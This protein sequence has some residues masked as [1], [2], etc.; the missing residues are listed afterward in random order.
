M[1]PRF[2]EFY[3]Q[4]LQYI[5]E[6]GQEFAQRYPKIAGR[7]GLSTTEV[8]DPYVERLLEGFA[9]LTGRVQY[10]LDQEFPA[11][12]EQL[13][14]CLQ[15]NA[16]AP[17]PSM[18]IVQIIPNLKDPQLKS[19]PEISG[20]TRLTTTHRSQRGVC[21][22]FRTSQDIQVWPISIE[23]VD[24][25]SQPKVPVW[26]KDWQGSRL[27]ST[28]SVRLQVAEGITLNQLEGLDYLDFFINSGDEHAY[29]FLDHLIANQVLTWVEFDN[30]EFS[31][32]ALVFEHLGFDEHQ[33]LLPDGQ[34]NFSGFRLIQEMMVFP[35]K[36]LFFRIKGLK[37]I[38]QK[39]ESRNFTIQLG[40]KQKMPQLGQ[41]LNADSLA[42]FCSP[43]I[44]W[45]E[46]RCD[47]STPKGHSKT[48]LLADRVH[49]QDYEIHS[50]VRVKGY[51]T[52]HSKGVEIPPLFGPGNHNCPQG[53]GYVFERHVSVESEVRKTQGGR[54]RY[55]GTDTYLSLQNPREHTELTG[56]FTQFSVVANCTN[57]D[58]PLTLPFGKGQSDF[59]PL[60]HLPSANIRMMRGPTRPVSRL[61]TGRQV[62]E[63]IEH[64][65][66]NYLSLIQ[67]E[68]SV[69][70]LHR[71]LSLYANPKEPG[72]MGLAQSV[73]QVQCQPAS[74]PIFCRG[75]SVF[76]RGLSV[77]IGLDAEHTSGYGLAIPGAV[78]AHYLSRFVSINS[79]VKT[80]VTSQQTGFDFTWPAL[81]GSRPV[82]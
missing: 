24:Y 11:F 78:L 72:Q 79:F 56:G 53:L 26:L 9:F 82:L 29:Q 19:G 3:S 33:A 58:L 8:E 50:I 12:C 25:Q 5:R 69:E 16:L 43:V 63:L 17:I 6:M 34:L 80:R 42:L 44:N 32:S 30:Q 21:A 66:L 77:E 62:W 36:F 41:S 48:L 61:Y 51:E 59:Q 67:G 10:K 45:F 40:L 7:L 55:L 23:K 38:L 60:A 39:V 27:V 35:E 15:P 73:M 54:S 46:H 52:P 64:S 37:R 81:A 14:Q 76:V 68:N 49:P 31:N 74:E 47:R 13:L 57:R 20:R 75:R 65:S 1:N 70:S 71:L 4:E 18:G 28:V 22:S 2:L